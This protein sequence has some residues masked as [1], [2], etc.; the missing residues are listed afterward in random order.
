[1]RI[2]RYTLLA[3]LSVV[4]VMGLVFGYTYASIK[5]PFSPRYI[6]WD[7]PAPI[8]DTH[9]KIYMVE[10]VLIREY[11]ENN[12]N[13]VST[14]DMP[15]HVVQAF[16]AIEDNRFYDH[17]GFDIKGM[18]RALTVNVRNREIK[19][20]GSTITQQLAR[21]LFL[22]HEQTAERKMLEIA[23]AFELER[24]FEK[25]EI[26]EMYLNQ[27]YFGKSN[28]GV[29]K[30]SQSYFKGTSVT[31]VDVEQAAMLAGIIQAPNVYGP[32]VLAN[33]EVAMDQ[34][35]IVLNRML[36]KGFITKNE[37]NSIVPEN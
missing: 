10:D 1:M 11:K 27:I 12:I 33:T 34:R 31:E 28:W 15:P 7:D 9:R 14:E 32:A 17:P 18:M 3:V 22:N 37:L 2:V 4:L 21:N 25:D 23:I 6:D 20:G 36:E 29:E 13:F 8:Y 26:M 5:V 30:A 35:Q 19:Q 24:Q 16:I